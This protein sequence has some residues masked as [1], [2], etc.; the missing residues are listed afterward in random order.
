LHKGC[1]AGQ[2]GGRPA[3][4]DNFDH[5]I[6][7]SFEINDNA[8]LDQRLRDILD[9]QRKALYKILSQYSTFDQFTSGSCTTGGVGTLELL[10]GPI[11]TKNSPGHM[12]PSAVT[13]FD[14]MF[15][16]HHA[17]VD[18]QLALYQ[19]V[20]P[21]TYMDPCAAGTPTFTIERGEILTADSG[22]FITLN[23]P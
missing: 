10:H 20:F 4:C 22:M 17:N 12:A 5:T 7:A 14:P 19:A 13:A 21:N 1:P 9:S 15:W 11:H 6:R 16:L 3:I 8:T 2:V 18:R 23:F